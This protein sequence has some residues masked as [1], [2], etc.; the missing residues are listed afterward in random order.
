M[1]MYGIHFDQM[2]KF[3]RFKYSTGYETLSMVYANVIKRERERERKRER[4][5]IKISHKNPC[6]IMKKK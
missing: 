1:I 5:I 2:N 4:S 3:L 6:F